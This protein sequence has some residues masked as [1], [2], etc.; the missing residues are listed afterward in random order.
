MAG[1]DATSFC[2]TASGQSEAVCISPPDLLPIVD[3]PIARNT[4]EMQA[5]SRSL[6][7]CVLP[8]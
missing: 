5:P 6:A 2:A 7:R 8:T 1:D 4:L 3:E